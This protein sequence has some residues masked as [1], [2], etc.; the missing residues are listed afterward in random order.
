M[1][2]WNADQ[3]GPGRHTDMRRLKDGDGHEHRAESSRSHPGLLTVEGIVV[4]GIAPP[5]LVAGL[6]EPSAT[7]STRLMLAKKLRRRIAPVEA[8]SDG[9]G[10]KSGNLQR[11]F[12][13]N[14][15]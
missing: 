13:F 4:I 1:K 14:I 9:H 10:L 5:W 7:K 11:S 8:P 6:T 15:L 3:K 12:S 2:Q